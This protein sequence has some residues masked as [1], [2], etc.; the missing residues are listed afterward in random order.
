MG[1]G[2][3]VLSAP[4][5]ALPAAFAGL[6]GQMARDYLQYCEAAKLDPDAELLAPVIEVFEKLKETEE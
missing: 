5:Q 1:E 6:I 2:I 4:F 3:R